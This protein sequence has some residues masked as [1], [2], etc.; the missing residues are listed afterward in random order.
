MRGVRARI[1]VI[2][3]VVLLGALGGWTW[4]ITSVFED[5]LADT[6]RSH[7]ELQVAEIADQLALEP[8]SK[9]LDPVEDGFGEVVAQVIGPGGTVIA[10][11]SAKAASRPLIGVAAPMGRTVSERVPELAGI[12]PDPFIVVARGARDAEGQPMT[13]VVASPVHVEEGQQQRLLVIGLASGSLLV[14][15]SVLLVRWAVGQALEPVERMRRQLA[16]MDSRA[17][18][19]R[20][21]VPDTGDELTDLGVTMNELLARIE[22]AHVAQEAFVSNASHE[23]RSPLA[24]L[25]AS[26]ELAVADE[27]GRTWRETRDVVETELHRVQRLVDDLLTLSRY[28]AGQVRLRRRP[29]DLD[30]LLIQAVRRLAVTRVPVRLSVE[31]V[32]AEVDADRL[33][34]VV[35]NLLDNAVRHAVTGVRVGLVLVDDTAV[36]RVDN[37]GPLLATE[38]LDA[39]FGRFV[40][41]DAGR[42]RDSGGSGLGL[43][44]AAD[45][46][47]A[48]GGTIT[49]GVAEDGWCRFEVRIPVADRPPRGDSR[50]PARSAGS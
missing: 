8:A 41:F 18:A 24:T 2:A 11:S 48:H 34:Q 38:E 29:T 14:L 23:L 37:D 35:R 16:G 12:D 26:V 47:H 36:I 25:R 21:D 4:L 6:A 15:V 40:R 20:V 50:P 32:Q 9:V 22:A 19:E 30:D 5:T 7:A 43:A 13:I 46:V 3:V 27:S 33:E 45:A 1:L 49:A 42:S 44:I 28:D 10:S 17:L 31:P 39:V